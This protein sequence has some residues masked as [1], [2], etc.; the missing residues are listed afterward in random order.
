MHPLTE[1]RQQSGLLDMRLDRWQGDDPGISQVSQEQARTPDH[2]PL[3]RRAVVWTVAPTQMAVE[4]REG[5]FVQVQLTHRQAVLKGPMDEVLRRSK[6]FASRN[7]G[8][9]RFR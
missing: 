6:M 7:R 4:S 1:G 5:L 9:A 2:F 3:F 8:V